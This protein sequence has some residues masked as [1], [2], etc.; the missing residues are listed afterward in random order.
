MAKKRSLNDDDYRRLLEF[1]AGVRQFLKWSESEA[2]KQGLTPT[3]HQLLLAVRGHDHH[4][5]PTISDVADC[6]LLRHHSAV[7]LVD[8]AETASL[9]R[10]VPDPDDRRLVRLALTPMGARKL[11]AITIRALEQ[12]DRIS[13]R[14]RGIWKAFEPSREG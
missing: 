11:E 4:R 5:G 6:L 8:R 2:A 13:P 7:E 14:L 9:V 12:L 1:R 3:Q 10:R